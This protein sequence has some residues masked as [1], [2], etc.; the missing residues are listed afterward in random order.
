[1]SDADRQWAYGTAPVTLADGRPAYER[2]AAIPLNP[3]RPH[4]SD[5]LWRANWPEIVLTVI[6]SA[7]VLFM[8][9][10]AM[11]VVAG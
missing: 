10:V 5:G 1:M 7:A 9:G 8:A 2:N 11:L 4:P 3:P 6:L